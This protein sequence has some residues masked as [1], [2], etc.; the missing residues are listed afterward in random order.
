MI[1]KTW[2]ENM[3]HV[4]WIDIHVTWLL[5]IIQKTIRN[6]FTHNQIKT[7]FLLKWKI[8]FILRVNKQYQT[9]FPIVRNFEYDE[10]I[11]F[12]TRCIDTTYGKQELMPRVL[13]SLV[14]SIQM[15]VKIDKCSRMSTM[16]MIACQK[17]VAW[18]KCRVNHNGFT[19]HTPAFV[20]NRS[21]H[22]QAEIK[23]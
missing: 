16:T 10:F 21:A 13:F 6:S 20:N 17:S 8:D 4:N 7:L 9:V 11:N 15:H 18:Y 5:C 2:I 22:R 12:S 14:K 19:T 23:W 3:S 1:F